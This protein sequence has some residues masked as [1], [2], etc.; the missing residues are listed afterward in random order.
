MVK[1]KY[2]AIAA[3]AAVVAGLGTYAIAKAVRTSVLRAEFR[4]LGDV[5]GDGVI[6]GRDITLIARAMGSR[7]G[8]S[9]WN[10]AC[11]LNGDGVVDST[12]LAIAEAHFELTF[13]QWLKT[14][15]LPISHSCPTCPTCKIS[16]T[17]P[18]LKTVGVREM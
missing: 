6:D 15:G 11:D 12:D 1:L 5:N 3:T 14:M 9:N 17:N 10:P 8:D 7:P 18:P 16:Y 2:V 13:D 4:K